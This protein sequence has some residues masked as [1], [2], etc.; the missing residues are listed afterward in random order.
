MSNINEAFLVKL[1]QSIGVSYDL[2]NRALGSA[3]NPNSALFNLSQIAS[4]LINGKPQFGVYDQSGA[5]DISFISSLNSFQINSGSV[6][7]QAKLI[8]VPSQSI[9]FKSSLDQPGKKLFK[10]Y[11]DYNDFIL[12]KQV[13]SASITSLTNYQIVVDQLPSQY[14]L[15]NFKQININGYLIN[16]QNINSSNKTITLTQDVVTSNIAS[17]GSTIVMIFQ[18]VVKF[19]V[20]YATTGTPPDLQIPNTGIDVAN[21]TISIDSSFNYTLYGLV[22]KTFVSYPFYQNPAQLFPNQDSYNSFL[23]LVNN[24]IQSYSQTQKYNFEVNLLKGYTDYTRA[25]SKLSFDD[26]WHTRPYMPTQDFE[27]G[28][29]FSNLQQTYFDSRFK[30]LWYKAFN[31]QLIKTFAIFRGDIFAGKQNLQNLG[32]AVTVS[33]FSDFSNVSSLFNG[34][35][36]YGVS[37]VNT[38]G[39]STIVYN[40]S[41]NNYFSNKVNNFISWTSINNYSP[42]FYHIY[43]NVVT[44]GIVLQQRLTSPYQILSSALYDNLI[45]D[46]NNA[47]IVNSSYSA[48]LIKSGINTGVIGGLQAWAYFDS[49]PNNLLGI[50]SVL[51]IEGGQNY[52]NPSVIISGNGIGCSI[53]LT[54][55]ALTGSIIGANIITMGSSFTQVP[56]LTVVDSP[57]SSGY[58]AVLQPIMSSVKIGIYTG[59]SSPVGSSIINCYDLPIYQIGTSPTQYAIPIKGANFISLSSSVNYWSVLNIN[60]PYGINT[61]KILNS[62]G[63]TGSISTSSNGTSWITKSTS[64]QIGKLGYLDQGSSGVNYFSKGIYLTNEKV[65][66]PTRLQI[67][68]PFMDLSS[69]SNSDLGLTTNISLPIQNSMIVSVAALNSITGISSNLTATIPQYT[70]RGTSIL[71]GSEQDVFDIVT[72]VSVQPNA[73]YIITKNGATQWSIYDLFTVDSKP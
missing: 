10:F 16:I 25:I 27:Y 2:K 19:I 49:T 42:L 15:N 65:P 39:E 52:T 1:A 11:L 17:A 54:T 34:S 66:S 5:F 35:Y 70:A 24:S 21:A 31:Q 3:N 23:S 37:G 26:Y 33:N 20:S 48:F 41:I 28:I 72:D 32:F 7:F 29:N 68:I 4:L 55:S 9:P 45:P 57:S 38:N 12:S 22:N 61:I 44:N 50:Q 60:M 36:T 56:I 69:L 62:I 67:F 14:Y 73:P 46:F 30:D 47:Q 53:S 8:N 18:P 64:A 63:F 51:I 59:N 40:T 43:K 6:F 13:F 58:G 71:L